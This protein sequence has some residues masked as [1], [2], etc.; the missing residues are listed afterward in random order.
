MDRVAQAL[1]P[2]HRKTIDDLKRHSDNGDIKAIL[3]VAQA[4]LDRT[5]EL[6]EEEEESKDE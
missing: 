5:A 2:E 4:A 6:L 3:G 1:P